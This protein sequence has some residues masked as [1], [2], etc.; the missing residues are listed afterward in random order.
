[1]APLHRHAPVSRCWRACA[2]ASLFVLSIRFKVF[3][4]CGVEE[5]LLRA[6]VRCFPRAAQCWTRV[7]REHPSLASARAICSAAL[8]NSKYTASAPVMSSR[9]SSAAGQWSR[10]RV[11]MAS[12]TSATP[13]LRFSAVRRR[14]SLHPSHTR[15]RCRLHTPQAP[16]QTQTRRPVQSARVDCERDGAC[17]SRRTS[18]R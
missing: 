18:R 8:K 9:G 1:M 6:G 13:S 15:C 10:A 17:R 2:C 12:A 16:P 14:L 5:A 3:F 11:L 4:V 7:A